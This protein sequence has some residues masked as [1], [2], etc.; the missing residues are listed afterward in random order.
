[1]N[2]SPSPGPGARDPNDE[3]EAADG[4]L[5]TEAI[6]GAEEPATSLSPTFRLTP[7]QFVP[8]CIGAQRIRTGIC[9]RERNVAVGANLVRRI[10]EVACCRALLAPSEGLKSEADRMQTSTPE[11][12]SQSAK[13]SPIDPVPTTSTS[14][15]MSG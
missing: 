2:V 3:L 8:A 4:M 10:L 11:R 1:L 12:F 6:W 14:G 7:A 13:T 15:L 9:V 5:E